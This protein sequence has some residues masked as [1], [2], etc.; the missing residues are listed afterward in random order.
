[1]QFICKSRIL[2]LQPET[3][4]KKVERESKLQAEAEAKAVSD[5]AKSAEFI[6][7]ITAK[8]QGF[9]QEY[10]EVSVLKLPVLI[11]MMRAT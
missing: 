11:L 10:N 2:T 6:A 8:A 9:E 3:R 1:M 7:N 4:L 5:A